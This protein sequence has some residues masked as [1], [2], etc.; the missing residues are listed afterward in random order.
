MYARC[1]ELWSEVRDQMRVYR[2]MVSGILHGSYYTAASI[3]RP[4][5][6][7]LSGVLAVV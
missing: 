2:N 3:F 4:P 1:R 5:D 6:Q 7:G